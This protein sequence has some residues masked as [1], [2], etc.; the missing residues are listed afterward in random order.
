ML[1]H[2]MFLKCIAHNMYNVNNFTNQIK[3]F[4]IRVHWVVIEIRVGDILNITR[5]TSIVSTEVGSLN[6]S[7]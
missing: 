3:S 2:L 5:N 6:L 1:M 4:P 7:V